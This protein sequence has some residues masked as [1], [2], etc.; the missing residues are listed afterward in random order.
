MP[1]FKDLF[2]HI[3]I[4]ADYFEFLFAISKVL[5]RQLHVLFE[6]QFIY[7]ENIRNIMYTYFTQF[8]L[9]SG[10]KNKNI[11]NNEIRFAHN[12]TMNNVETH[13]Y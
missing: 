7:F 8:S 5:F 4:L 10:D 11:L 9:F 6:R 2:G 12:T 1:N 13:F 3:N